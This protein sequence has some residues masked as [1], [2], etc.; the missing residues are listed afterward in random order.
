MSTR[1]KSPHIILIMTDQHT[2]TALGCAGNPVLKTPAIDSIA[3]EGVRFENAYCSSPICGPARASLFTGLPVEEHGI[4]KNWIPLKPGTELITDRLRAA[5]YTAALVGKLHISPCHEKHGFDIHRLCDSPHDVYDP[6]EVVHNDYLR[7]LEKKCPEQTPQ[8]LVRL[9]GE[10]ERLGGSDPRFWQGWSWMDDDR[11]LTTWTGEESVEIIEHHDA[12]TPLFLNIS[13][14]GPHH[15]YKT[16]EPWDSMYSPD[17]VPLPDT[18][19]KEFPGDPGGSRFP[20]W[21]EA[22]WREMIAAFYGNI[23]SIDVQIGRIIES[24]K[25]RGMWENSLV[26]FTADHGDSMG[27]FS[28]LGKGT[29]LDSSVKIPLIIKPPRSSSARTE[30]RNVSALDLFA[31]LADYAG[32]AG[33][34]PKETRSLRGVLEQRDPGW[35]DIVYATFGDMSGNPLC[36]VRKGDLKLVR[37]RRNPAESFGLYDCGPEGEGDA[38]NLFDPQSPPD[39]LMGLWN[40][41]YA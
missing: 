37:R 41:K 36:M 26:I 34:L 1:Q 24:L 19:K 12:D 38:V 14:F 40:V 29:M 20:D 21:P 22:R 2:A 23:S 11:Q 6:E 25:T 16:C 32:A 13:F 10:S 17:E 5:G 30:R 15:P 18:L 39:E 31:T 27:D 8:E 35:P 7:W 28:R 33:P 3:A 4:F 9:A